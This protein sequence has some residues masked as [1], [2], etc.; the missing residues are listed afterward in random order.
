MNTEGLKS[1]L[2]KFIKETEDARL[3]KKVSEYVSSLRKSKDHDWAEDLSVEQ[4]KAIEKGLDD[5]KHG[6]VIPHNEV[7]KKLSE[8]FPHLKFT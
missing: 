7:M 3:L 5:V 4:I 8:K 1:E 2:L 6:R